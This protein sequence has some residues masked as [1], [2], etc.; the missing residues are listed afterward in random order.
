MLI[1]TPL[2]AAPAVIASML[3]LIA[4]PAAAQ[5]PFAHLPAPEGFS[6]WL[7]IGITLLIVFAAAGCVLLYLA[8]LQQRFLSACRESHELVLFA[9]HP[10]GV[11]EGTVR[12]LLALFIVFASIGFLALAMLPVPGVKEFPELMA[13]ILGSVLGFYF[14]ARATVPAGGHALEQVGAARAERDRALEKADRGQLETV[15]DN[16]QAGVGVARVVAKVLPAEAGSRIE[17]AAA[18]VE[19]GLAA[20]DR[21]R[22]AGGAQQA[23]QELSGLAARLQDDS[24]IN[25]VLG[26]AMTSFAGVLGGALPP[27]AIASAVVGIGSKLAGAAYDRWVARVLHAPYTPE[28]FPPSVVDANTAISL[29]LQSPILRDAFAAELDRG[30][31]R[32]FGE[33]L[34]LAL[35]EERSEELWSRFA[36]RFEDRAAFEQGLAEFQR[37]ALTTELVKDV[38]PAWTREIG[39]VD[40]LLS[41]IDQLNAD[42]AARGDL[43]AMVLIADALKREGKAPDQLFEA[44]RRQVE[45]GR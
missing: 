34:E 13:G 17:Q 41:A 20:V 7:P 3:C 4:P 39:G 31:R 38:E 2:R 35:S 29:V 44:A 15:R 6:L 5:A 9:Q 16:V 8:R 10:A 28:L 37:A 22:A 25:G 40:P 19:D 27:L 32:F 30:D 42:P 23:L 33:L 24:P 11:P 18:V 26:R 12:S 14:G 21:L 45:G 36:G 43:D 1:P